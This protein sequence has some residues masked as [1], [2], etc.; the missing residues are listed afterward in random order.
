MQIPTSITSARLKNITTLLGIFLSVSIIIPPFTGNA[1]IV[2]EADIQSMALGSPRLSDYQGKVPCAVWRIAKDYDLTQIGSASVDGTLIVLCAP[3]A[4]MSWIAQELYAP[5]DGTVILEQLSFF[6]PSSGREVARMVEKGAPQ[7]SPGRIDVRL[8]NSA[9]GQY[10][11]A[12]SWKKE[13]HSPFAG[14]AMW[15][16]WDYPVWEFEV[17]ARTHISQKLIYESSSGM[18]PA[19]YEDKDKN[20]KRYE[21]VSYKQAP[22]QKG[23]YM[24]WDSRPYLAFSFDKGTGEQKRQLSR[25][26]LPSWPYLPE[27]FWEK[28][29]GRISLFTARDVIE[30]F[31]QKY[32][33][34]DVPPGSARTNRGADKRG[35]WTPLEAAHVVANSL[36]LNMS[37]PVEI[38]YESLT[39]VGKQ[40]PSLG[41]M[42]SP[43][44][45][46]PKENAWHVPGSGTDQDKIPLKLRGR[47]MYRVNGKGDLMTKKLKIQPPTANKLNVNWKL[48]L[49]EDSTVTG[50]VDIDAT[51]EWSAMVETVGLDRLMGMLY[52]LQDWAAR[53]WR[54]RIEVSKG[55]D[56]VKLR[57]PINARCGIAN[58]NRTEMLTKLPSFYPAPLIPLQQAENI[59]ALRCPLMVSQKYEVK[60]PG[61]YEFLTTLGQ[62]HGESP[63]VR[64]DSD[65]VLENRKTLL[66]G[67]EELVIRDVRIPAV[68][69]GAFRQCLAT[70]GVW[71]TNT[72]AMRKK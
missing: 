19:V 2:S 6:D 45:Y 8:P 35:P 21:W 3:D 65:Y 55:H 54:S 57:I 13:T 41:S 24:L 39:D 31:W 47:L 14:T 36:S 38:W 63:A 68:E 33:F 66:K 4:S 26:E 27:G 22:V 72:I 46:F 70:L 53:D 42:Y 28:R 64:F 11:V 20:Q 71:R 12:M 10:I 58:A 61:G 48:S 37:Q 56:V 16:G 51:G 23:I 69:L 15:T 5:T 17:T 7:T 1:K 34:L 32:V 25:L 67:F 18:E 59:T 49:E 60:M 44:F 62:R 30:K 29:K 9:S 43:V 50:T 52:G 40:G